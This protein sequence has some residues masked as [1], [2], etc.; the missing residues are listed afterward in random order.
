M[1]Y[2]IEAKELE[3]AYDEVTMNNGEFDE[4]TQ[5]FLGE[6]ITDGREITK[7]ELQKMMATFANDKGET[8]SYWM[9][10]KLIHKI[11]YENTELG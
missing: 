7:E 9:D 3:H 4:V 2:V 1:K 11:N 5:R 10:E 6:Q 8:C